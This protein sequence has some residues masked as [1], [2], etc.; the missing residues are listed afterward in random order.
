LPKPVLTT[1]TDYSRIRGNSRCCLKLC[2]EMKDI[3]PITCRFRQVS[4][5]F[6]SPIVLTQWHSSDTSMTLGNLDKFPHFFPLSLLR[7]TL[8]THSLD[9]ST[10]LKYVETMMTNEGVKDIKFDY[11]VVSFC[12]NRWINK[13]QILSYFVLK[14]L[15]NEINCYILMHMYMF[16]FSVLIFFKWCW[17]FI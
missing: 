12:D 15:F 6:F 16:L 10:G 11:N 17:Y 2:I 1:T 4:Q 8:D 14:I 3:N 13:Y 5:I 9:T 7:H